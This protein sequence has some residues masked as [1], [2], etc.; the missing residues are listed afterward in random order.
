M[1]K[2]NAVID[3]IEAEVWTPQGETALELL[4]AVYRNPRQPLGVRMRAA[5]LALPFEAP[6]L[7][8]VAMSNMDPATFAAQL[9]RAIGRSDAVRVLPPPTIIDAEPV[10]EDKRPD[11]LFEIVLVIK[12]GPLSPPRER[13]PGPSPHPPDTPMGWGRHFH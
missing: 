12:L 11:S 4:R 5:A 2:I 1:S 10:P 8:A 7:S 3:L 9:E 13:G 6:K